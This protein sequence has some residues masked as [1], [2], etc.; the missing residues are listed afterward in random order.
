MPTYSE[1]LLFT[2][3]P[4]VKPGLPPRPFPRH[5]ISTRH[6][7]F[8]HPVTTPSRSPTCSPIKN[9]F[10]YQAT[11]TAVIGAASSAKTDGRCF[12]GSRVVML[13]VMVEPFSIGWRVPASATIVGAWGRGRGGRGE[14]GNSKEGWVNVTR[15]R[16]RGEGRGTDCLW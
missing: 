9:T 6:E 16:E 15:C 11:P 3:F 7:S 1:W 5:P 10:G 12:G 2:H 4:R 8:G 13:I 14:G